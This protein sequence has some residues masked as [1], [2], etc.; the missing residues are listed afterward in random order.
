VA[1][2]QRPDGKRELRRLI[3][4]LEAATDAH[5]HELAATHPPAG[6][7]VKKTC[8]ACAK[9]KPLRNFQRD[10]RNRDGRRG[11]CKPCQAKYQRRR[12]LGLPQTLHKRG[13]KPAT[14]T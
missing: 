2:D 8:I 14:P 12:T 4:Q 10:R 6:S 9:E 1:A 3:A 7:A 11:R 5:A 13:R